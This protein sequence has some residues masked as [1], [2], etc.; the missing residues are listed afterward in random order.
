MRSKKIIKINYKTHV[1]VRLLALFFFLSVPIALMTPAG[2]QNPDSYADKPEKGAQSQSA[3]KE[4]G[5]ALADPTGA[6]QDAIKVT[7]QDAILMALEI[8]AP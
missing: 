6:A 1:A 4:I 5:K 3:Q 8:T 2:A 7:V